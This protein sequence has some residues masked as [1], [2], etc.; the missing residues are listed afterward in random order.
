MGRDLFAVVLGDSGLQLGPRFPD[1]KHHLATPDC[2]FGVIAGGRGNSDGWNVDIPGDDDGTVG[3]TETLL[4]G[5]ADFAVIPVRHME[6]VSD[7]LAMHM[8]MTFLRRGYFESAT[9]RVPIPWPAQAGSADR[10]PARVGRF[11]NCR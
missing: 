2:E 6:L 8:T 11:T 4:A 5:A 10:P 3:V 9:A 1:I 7:D